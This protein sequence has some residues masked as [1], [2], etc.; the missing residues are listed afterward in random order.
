MANGFGSFYVGQS[1][2]L[3]AQNAINVTAN[4][5]ANVNTTGYVREQV[6]FSDQKY[7]VRNPATPNTNVQQS[8]LGVSISDV[9]HARDIFLDK[10]YRQEAGRQGFYETMHKSVTYVEEILQ[11]MDGQEFKDGISDM[12]KAFQEFA[13]DPG[14]STNQNLVLQKAELFLSRSLSVY[15][16]LQDYQSNINLQIKDT[17]DRINQIGKE[18]YE[19]NLKIQKIEAGGIETA[20][21]DRDTRDLLLDELAGYVKIEVEEDATGF[22]FV[23]MEG[24]DLITAN[25]FN[26]IGL[27]EQRGSGFY[28]PYWKHLSDTSAERYMYLIDT[29]QT[30]STSMNTDI[31]SLKALMIAR[32]DTYG[33]FDFLSPENYDSVEDCVVMETQADISYLVNQMVTQIN[34]VLCP[35][36]EAGQIIGADQMTSFDDNG[37]YLAVQDE[38]GNEYR[39][40][41]DTKI[42]DEKSCS[43]GADGK[44]PPQ[45]LFVRDGYP[46]YTE[47]TAGDGSTYYVYNEETEANVSS[48]YKLGNVSINSNLL[49]EVTNMPSLKQDGS[50]DYEI[51]NKLVSLFE[52]ETLRVT[53]SD[54]IPC[55]FEDFYD[56]MMNRL[57]TAGNVYGA[58]SETL[59]STVESI[60]NQRQQIMGV[61]SDEELTHMIK[62]QSAYNAASRYITV[63]SEMT[64]LIV[65]L[66]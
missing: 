66:I 62:F 32:G 50:V 41:A 52:K 56:K 46:R 55:T 2:L 44:I 53:P 65:Q 35:N 1:G 3:S 24:V 47:V 20:M 43:V 21:A 38:F 13:K 57:G 9:A 18:L 22:T 49:K 31:G 16:N 48:W 5:L 64:D 8:G 60:D 28:R 40:Y 58:A 6:R 37:A 11:E 33:T 17:V 14:N 61:S 30:I 10:S 51:G 59:T 36:K 39:I 45:E 7:I 27:E 54:S 25:K 15:S 63:I 4:N 26:E 29:S 12:W 34:D 42:L 23:K 19:I